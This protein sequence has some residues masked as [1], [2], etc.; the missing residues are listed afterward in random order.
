M[1]H[2]SIETQTEEEQKQKPSN[3]EVVK[4]VLASGRGSIT[5]GDIAHMQELPMAQQ[6]LLNPRYSYESSNS[7]E[8]SKNMETTLYGDP[9]SPT[10][11]PKQ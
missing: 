11:I 6:A 3:M 5:N 8:R 7:G 10:R 9:A 4:S 2:M 1:S